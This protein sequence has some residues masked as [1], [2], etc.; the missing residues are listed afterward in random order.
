MRGDAPNQLNAGD[1][2]GSNG[3]QPVHAAA[4]DPRTSE[5]K[6]IALY[7]DLTGESESAA[8]NVYSHLGL[9]HHDSSGRG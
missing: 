1:S 4:P 2:N 8:R 5:E 9:V 7:M 3:P 6:M